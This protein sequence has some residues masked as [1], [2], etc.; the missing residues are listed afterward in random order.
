MGE[1][2]G[3][4]IVAVWAVEEAEAEVE[5]RLDFLAGWVLRRLGAKEGLPAGAVE[6]VLRAKRR[7]KRSGLPFQPKNRRLFAVAE[8]VRPAL[9]VVIVLMALVVGEEG[10]RST[11][12]EAVVRLEAP[13]LMKLAAREELQVAREMLKVAEVELKVLRKAFAKSEVV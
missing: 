13:D 10:A 7:G 4:K 6:E 3:L 1:E 8:E 2:L 11:R 9:E 5:L 12:V